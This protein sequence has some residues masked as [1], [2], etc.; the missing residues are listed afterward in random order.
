[1]TNE[2]AKRLITSY[3]AFLYVTPT[4]RYFIKVR[5]SLTTSKY[6]FLIPLKDDVDENVDVGDVHLAVTVHVSNRDG[7]ISSHDDVDDGIDVG[8]IDL[9]VAVHITF[10]AFSFL[11]IAISC[12]IPHGANKGLSKILL[13]ELLQ[14]T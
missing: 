8:D 5:H 2:K 6:L 7:T 3:L 1:M 12:K 11:F 14:S 10:V 13:I 4:G 9:K